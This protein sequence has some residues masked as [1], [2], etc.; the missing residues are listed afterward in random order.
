MEREQEVPMFESLRAAVLATA[1][2]TGNGACGPWPGW[3]DKRDEDGVQYEEIVRRG[4]RALDALNE[5]VRTARRLLDTADEML[6]PY[7]EGG[8]EHW[9][10]G[11]GVY[12]PHRDWDGAD[13][14]SMSVEWPNLGIVAD[15]LRAVLAR[16]E[17][18]TP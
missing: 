8:A 17:E 13:T 12:A 7:A 10:G 16:V 14:E 4:T 18:V 6:D 11:F 9:Y 3:A 15:E 2:H 5:L 1:L